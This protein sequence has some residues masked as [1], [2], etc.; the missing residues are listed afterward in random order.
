MQGKSKKWHGTKEIIYTVEIN[1]FTENLIVVYYPAGAGGKFITLALN[2]H[3]QI[4][5]Q[6]EIFAKQKLKRNHSKKIGYDIAR[7]ILDKTVGSKQ[8]FELGCSQMAG[9]N[10]VDLL[11]DPEADQRRSNDFWKELTNQK[12]HYFFMICHENNDQFIKYRKKKQIIL[13]NF[14]WIMQKRNKTFN[15]LNFFSKK[16]FASLEFDMESLLSKNTFELEIEKVFNFLKLENNINLEFL[17]QLRIDFLHS[18]EIGFK[19]E[20]INDQQ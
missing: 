9:F 17:D 19:P 15:R 13:K 6:S 10:G 12:S 7:S 3:Q 14:D 5:P 1:Y 4:L 20:R 8:H 2:L 16:S 18:F 11:E